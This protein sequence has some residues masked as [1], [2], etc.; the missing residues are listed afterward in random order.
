MRVDFSLKWESGTSLELLCNYRVGRVMFQQ[1]QYVDATIITTKIALQKYTD[2]CLEN[3][4]L[5]DIRS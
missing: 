5:Q 2:V 1:K 3:K 4:D